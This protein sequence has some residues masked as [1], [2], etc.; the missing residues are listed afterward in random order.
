MVESF[1]RYNNSSLQTRKETFLWQIVVW[2]TYLSEAFTVFK[3]IKCHISKDLFGNTSQSGHSSSHFITFFNSR[4]T[5]TSMCFAI[6]YSWT[7]YIISL[8][9]IIRI[10]ICYNMYLMCCNICLYAPL[11]DILC[12]IIHISL[13]KILVY[14]YIPAFRSLSA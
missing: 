7:L 8:C 5:Y 2:L 1:S 11:Y 13:C 14:F 9:N 3:V 12:I 6:N 4:M 10:F